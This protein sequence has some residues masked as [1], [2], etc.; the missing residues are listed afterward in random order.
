M[1]FVGDRDIVGWDMR[2]LLR[3]YSIHPIYHTEASI[4]FVQDLDERAQ[5]LGLDAF[6]DG[7]RGGDAPFNNSISTL[8]PGMTAQDWHYGKKR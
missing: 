6:D 3:A 8:K 2:D 7:Y 5:A 1:D 4:A